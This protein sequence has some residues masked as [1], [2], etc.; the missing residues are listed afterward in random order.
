MPIPLS[1]P[2]G[3]G[4]R[5]E[6]ASA[7]SPKAHGFRP[8]LQARL[9]FAAMMVLMGGCSGGQNVTPETVATAKKLWSQAKIRDYDL[10]LSV[11]GR[12]NAN[13]FVMVPRAR[14][15]GSSP[16]SATAARSS[17]PCR[18]RDSIRWT[19]YS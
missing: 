2:D 16:S 12:N 17:Y 8:S 9:G 19:A 13:Y 11:R 14:S 6:V 7:M 3:A 10:S 1:S 4:S 18:R 15:A 5:R